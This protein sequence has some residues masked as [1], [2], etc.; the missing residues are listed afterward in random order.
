MTMLAVLPQGSVSSPLLIRNWVE[1][2]LGGFSKGMEDTGP[3]IP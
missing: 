2:Y 1:C 3:E